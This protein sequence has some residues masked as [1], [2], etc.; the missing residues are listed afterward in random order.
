MQRPP[1]HQGARTGPPHPPQVTWLLLALHQD[2][3]G[4]RH[5]ALFREK[6]EL[7]ALCGAWVR[8][9]RSAARAPPRFWGQG[10]SCTQQ[11]RQR[12]RGPPAATFA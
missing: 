2:Q 10:G 6:A 7:A 4:N 9:T 1:L 8:A 5:L 3:P 11:R 12:M